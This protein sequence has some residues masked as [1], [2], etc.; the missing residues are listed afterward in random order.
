MRDLGK[1]RYL[2]KWSEAD[3][4]AT[5]DA[6]ASLGAGDLLLLLK[7]PLVGLQ[8]LM[9][10]AY[11]NPELKAR[12]DAA[13]SRRKANIAA[14][15]EA[16]YVEAFHKTL[17]LIRAGATLVE[18]CGSDPALP[19]YTT[20]YN[21]VRR[22]PDLR[23]KLDETF[24]ARDR[25]KWNA[26]PPAVA[27]IEIE[28]IIE[29][30]R[31]GYLLKDA[32]DKVSE[33]SHATIRTFLRNNPAIKARIDAAVTARESGPKARGHHAVAEKLTW[34][35][36]A[37]D[38]ALEAVRRHR[39]KTIHD[40]LGSD[41]PTYNSVW[42]RAQCSPGFAERY[43]DALGEYKA[44][45]QTAYA[46]QPK[47]V[48]AKENLRRS[49]NENKLYRE[50]SKLFQNYHDPDLRDDLISSVV[51]AVLD[52]EIDELA[53]DGADFAWQQHRKLQLITMDT[54][55]RPMFDK[56]GSTLGD[57]IT[58]DQWTFEDAI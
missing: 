42:R 37:Y 7:P 25:D 10:R 24:A 48:Y 29:L 50:V 38:E 13:K 32:F 14:A 12:I 53:R 57:T 4:F 21:L 6:I 22:H 18:A 43:R 56:P 46:K 30:V 20:I 16:R 19:D 1:D 55:D 33:R 28:K 34:S 2:A 17:P 3:L 39:G 26:V 11:R 8:S 49:L 41:R 40:V 54:L 23:N 35:D 58:A 15:V 36:A 27:L 9:A 44:W 5:A 52:G 45:R 47:R 31:S 51:I